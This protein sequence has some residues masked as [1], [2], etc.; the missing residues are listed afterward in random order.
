[1]RVNPAIGHG[2]STNCGIIVAGNLV[3]WRVAHVLP[4]RRF[5]HLCINLQDGHPRN[6]VQRR[7]GPALESTPTIYP[8]PSASA[9]QS[10]TL[11][12]RHVAADATSNGDHRPLHACPFAAFRRVHALHAHPRAT[13]GSHATAYG[14]SLTPRGQVSPA[15]P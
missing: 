8:V 13:H 10:R 1:M 2:G 4:N 14:G 15:H 12:G 6:Q 9:E 3:S 11:R 7:N 5:H